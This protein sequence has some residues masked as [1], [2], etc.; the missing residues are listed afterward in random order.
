MK[1]LIADKFPD[2]KISEIE[3]LAGSVIYD[4][5]LKEEALQTTLMKEQPDILIVRSTQVTGEMIEAASR[6]NLIIRAGSGVNTIDVKTAS[7]RSVYVAN[8]PGKNSIAVAELAFGLILS[9]D[10]RIPD[11]VLELRTGHWNKKE[12]SKARGVFGS[13]LGIIGL[14]RIGREML[15]RA[16]AFGMHVIA[17]SRSLTVEKAE[18]LGVAYAENPQVLAGK[19]DVVSVHLALTPQTRGMIGAEFF[20]KMKP[21][22]C[23]INTSRAEIIDQSALLRAVETRGI[24]AGL[25]VFLQEPEV[26][27]GPIDPEMFQKANLYATH[28]IG[29]STDQ[30]QNAVADETVRIVKEY[31]NTGRPLNCVNLLVRTPARYTLSVHHRNRVGILAGVLDVIRDASI[32]VETMENVIFSDAEGACARIQIDGKLSRAEV[33]KIETSSNDIFSVTQVE[34]G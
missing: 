1:V 23:I 34:I 13:T 16:N 31:L 19:A 22:A 3:K 28:H 32:N 7:E 29:A 9:L 17:W 25:D 12:F 10:R 2:D 26:K 15:P 6:L 14:G 24:R 4:Q 33:K 27:E 30:A 18:E 8:C 11:N 21:G 5:S 20:E